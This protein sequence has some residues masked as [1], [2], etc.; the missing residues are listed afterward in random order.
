MEEKISFELLVVEGPFK[1]RRFEIRESGTRLGRSSS[2]D[3]AITEDMALSRNHCLFEIVDGTVL[4]TDLASA[5]GTLLN[6][7]ALGAESGK[8]K[9]GDV[10]Q[11]GD[12]AI[13]LVEAGSEDAGVPGSVDLGL[14]RPDGG[15]SPEENDGKVSSS[16][17]MRIVVWF[18]TLLVVGGAIWA[19]LG[20]DGFGSEPK[21][22]L[23]QSIASSG[24]LHSFYYEK[25]EASPKGIYRYSISMKDDGEISVEVDDVPKENRHVRKTAKLSASAME[26]ISRM[27]VPGFKDQ[28]AEESSLVADLYRLEREYAGVPFA[29]GSYDS[30]RLRIVAGAKVLSVSCENTQKPR[31]LE[32]ICRKLETFSKNELGMWAIQYSAEK[33]IELSK[34][35]R[36]VGNAKWEERDVQYGNLAAALA[37]YNEA[38]FY[39][40]TVNPKPSDYGELLKQ[41]DET[42]AELD[43][44]YR[45]QRFMADRAINLQDWETAK[46]E[47]R[48]L[49]DLVPDK[50]DPR[51]TEASG[52]LMDVESRIKKG[53][54]R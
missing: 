4:V 16:P 52:K 45:D 50:K 49:C 3:I 41:R 24:K 40:D 1:G 11:V 22:A 10:V 30:V 26:T 33:L 46:R 54:S 51:H 31:A 48:I 39:L 43:R 44:R 32:E 27:L 37:A 47:L 9:I 15:T 21:D 17:L 20:S 23:E 34:E 25:V 5:N 2:C 38:V 29:P 28:T 42:A 19:I 35:S 6:G 53:G 8:L 14:D 36:S 7:E 18:A 13:A 12:S